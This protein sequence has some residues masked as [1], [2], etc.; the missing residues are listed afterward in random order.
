MKKTYYILRHNEHC[1][2]LLIE[3]VIGSEFNE[4]CFISHF[5]E[6]NKWYIVNID[7]GLTTCSERTRKTCID[8]YKKIETLLLEHLKTDIYKN[9]V[10]RFNEYLSD[11]LKYRKEVNDD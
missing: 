7:T 6:E 10:K 8:K 5:K 3:E 1:T 11:Y 9:Q 2:G 4:Y